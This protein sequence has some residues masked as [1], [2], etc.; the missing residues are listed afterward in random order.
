MVR[1]ADISISTDAK[2]KFDNLEHDLND[3]ELLQFLKPELMKSPDY[4]VVF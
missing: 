4:L 2:E 1:T 3:E